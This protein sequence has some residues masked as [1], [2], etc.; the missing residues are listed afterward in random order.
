VGLALPKG[1]YRKATKAKL[2][3]TDMDVKKLWEAF[4]DVLARQSLDPD[5]YRGGFH[6]N[7]I[8]TDSYETNHKIVVD[9]ANRIA[10]DYEA[11]RIDPRPIRIEMPP[12][13]TV[14]T[15]GPDTAFR[16]E[17][18]KVAYDQQLLDEKLYEYIVE[19]NGQDISLTQASEDL[20]VSKEEIDRSIDRLCNAGRL[21]RPSAPTIQ[22]QMQN[23]MYC[24][25]DTPSG[26]KFC[27]RCGQPQGPQV[28]AE[29]PSL[30]G[31]T[32]L[33]TEPPPDH[34]KT[35]DA[36]TRER[37]LRFDLLRHFSERKIQEH[38]SA[39][40]WRHLRSQK[41]FLSKKPFGRFGAGL[42]PVRPKTCPRCRHVLGPS[43]YCDHCRRYH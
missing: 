10:I 7:I 15:Q 18:L 8:L 13:K 33:R 16:R 40:M 41:Q 4:A 19:R 38:R 6:E 27:I 31:Q 3:L 25:G 22:E 43:G 1:R 21:P 32:D 24:S 42:K 14:Q 37:G 28:E 26:S 11:S 34:M 36:R 30:I 23:C 2:A 39:D 20:G 5:A 12:P 29:T 17:D 35:D 9:L